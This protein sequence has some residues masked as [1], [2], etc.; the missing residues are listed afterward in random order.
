MTA[1]RRIYA[2]FTAYDGRVVMP[3]LLE[4]SDFLHFRL[5]Y[6]EWAGRAEQGDGDLPAED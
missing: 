4:T 5:H 3:E 1:R 6:A 2:T